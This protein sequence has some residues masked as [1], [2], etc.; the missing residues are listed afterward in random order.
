MQCLYNLFSRFRK[1][2]SIDFLLASYYV[3]MY[4]YSKM[5]ILDHL[6]Y[7]CNLVGSLGVNR[8]L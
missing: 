3:S 4:F 1:Y 7:S 8:F 5:I 6:F 2:V